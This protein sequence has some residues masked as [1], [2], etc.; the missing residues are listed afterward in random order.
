MYP[1]VAN[2]LE[3][4]DNMNIISANCTR[5]SSCSDDSPTDSYNESDV[6]NCTA[7]VDDTGCYLQSSIGSYQQVFHNFEIRIAINNVTVHYRYNNGIQEVLLAEKYIIIFMFWRQHIKSVWIMKFLLF[8]DQY[9]VVLSV[10]TI[11]Q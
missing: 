10:V 7:P 8:S 5:Y 6:I 2:E 9:L 11:S 1:L 3:Y 4:N